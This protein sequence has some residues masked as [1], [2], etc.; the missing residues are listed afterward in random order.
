[1]VVEVPVDRTIF[2]LVLFS[3][4]N[5]SQSGDARA[6]ELKDAAQ[7]I[8]LFCRFFYS[9]SL[10]GVIFHVLSLAIGAYPDSLFFVA[11]SKNCLPVYFGYSGKGLNFETFTFCLFEGTWLRDWNWVNFLRDGPFSCRGRGN[12]YFRE[13][14]FVFEAN[15]GTFMNRFQSSISLIKQTQGTLKNQRESLIF[16]EN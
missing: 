6:S 12:I 14:L 7:H 2:S 1:M 11:R 10:L 16:S 4:C 13:Y 3:R 5:F 8:S 15:P 9:V